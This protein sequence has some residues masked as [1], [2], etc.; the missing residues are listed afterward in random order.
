MLLGSRIQKL[1][2]LGK[3]LAG[4]ELSGKK[5]ARLLATIFPRGIF[6]NREPSPLKKVACSSPVL[7]KA[8]NGIV[9]GAN[10]EDSKTPNKE[11]VGTDI[12]VSTVPSVERSAFKGI[13]PGAKTYDG[14]VLKSAAVGTDTKP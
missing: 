9:L 10:S 3:E 13:E 5:D 2:V 11:D 1:P 12:P 4:I 14:S 7:C 6:D 8:T